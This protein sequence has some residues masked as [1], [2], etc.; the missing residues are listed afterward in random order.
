MI[1]RSPRWHASPGNASPARS[2]SRYA[3]I[4]PGRGGGFSLLEV[5]LALAILTGAVTVLGGVAR[6][7]L[8]NAQ[9]A[10]DMTQ[11]QLLCESKMAEITSGFTPATPVYRAE[12]DVLSSSGTTGRITGGSGDRWLY[13]IETENID[14]DG[15][16]AVYVTVTQGEEVR[17]PVEFRL[18][19]WMLGSAAEG[20]EESETTDTS[21]ESSETGSSS[22]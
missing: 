7:G 12:F 17:R 2:A 9:I 11:A 14:E 16:M 5:I 3:A 15:L 19:R 18:V 13:S 22:E 6:L 4:T 21:S 1:P 20:L 8:R 10:R